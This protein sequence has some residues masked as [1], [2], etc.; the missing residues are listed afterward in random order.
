MRLGDA[1]LWRLALIIALPLMVAESLDSVLWITDTY[2]VSRLGD[3]AVAAVG[4]G[5]YLSW[6]AWTVASIFYIGTLVLVSQAIGAGDR[7]KA[8]RAVQEATTLSLVV[9]L[10]VAAAFHLLS[11][12][13]VGLVA[14]SRVSPETR[15]LAVEYFRLR[16]LGVYASYPATVASA[17]YRATGRTRPVMIAGAAYTTI[18]IV[19]DPL[20]I[21]GLGGLPPLG[22]RGAAVASSIATIVYLALLEAYLPG[23]TGLRP[24]IARPTR[25]SVVLSRVGA[26]TF[27]ERIL[28]VVGHLAYLGIV[29]R[30]GDKSL[31]AHTIG[32]RVE[33]LEFLPLFS[34]G[35][36]TAA[37]VGQA[38][39]EGSPQ[40]AKRRSL[41]LSKLNLLTGTL[42]GLGVAALSRPLPM[43]FTHD[44]FTAHLATTYLA[45][46]AATEPLFGLSISL[47]MS[48][49]GAGNTSTPF[50]VNLASYYS[51][52]ALLGPL[53]AA[54]MPGPYCAI[55]AWLTM[56]LDLGSRAILLSLLV[57]R[58]FHK[59]AR[60]LV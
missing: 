29:A 52:R 49:R 25:L 21:F 26:P 15:R 36:V 24:G 50:I 32:V 47:A 9:G 41:E 23:A 11:P 1:R 55:G 2:F 16:L 38:M 45:L 14:G 44:P 57:D 51:T 31:A 6:L 3:T 34:L 18:N 10:P 33:S 60:R 12:Q 58:M 30:C 22:V 43:M 53:L 20:L 39:G 7:N 4:L 56:A 59:L 17:A 35:E 19:L 28:L 48:L 40:E 8:S 37:L 5:G 13:A 27:A 46:A 42:V 54:R